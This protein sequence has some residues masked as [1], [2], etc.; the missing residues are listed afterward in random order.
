MELNRQPA[1]HELNGTCIAKHT[2]AERLAG[3]TR[4]RKEFMGRHDATWNEMKENYENVK[5]IDTEVLAEKRSPHNALYNVGSGC[6]G[7]RGPSKGSKIFW[8]F[9][10]F[11]FFKIWAT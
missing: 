2:T 8:G 4:G 10:C 1:F 11:S 5:C 3:M 6:C 7:E 9:F